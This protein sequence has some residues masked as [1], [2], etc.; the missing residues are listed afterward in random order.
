MLTLSYLCFCVATLSFLS[1]DFAKISDFTKA[2]K[3]PI[4]SFLPPLYP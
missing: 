2:E 4:V 1:M 3:L